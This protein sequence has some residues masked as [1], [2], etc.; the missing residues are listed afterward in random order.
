MYFLQAALLPSPV[1]GAPM[2]A[3]VTVTLRR[4]G[5]GWCGKT[6]ELFAAE[7]YRREHLLMCAACAQN[8]PPRG[9]RV[10]PGV[11][12]WIRSRLNA[13]FPEE[14]QRFLRRSGISRTRLAS[15][16]EAWCFLANSRDLAGLFD[17]WGQ[18]VAAEFITEPYASREDIEAQVAGFAG[19]LEVAYSISLPSWH[20]PWD[21]GCLR[22]VFQRPE[23]P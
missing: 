19:R 20:R 17:H 1:P 9:E 15:R 4:A 6:A 16:G 13:K 5:C 8:P 12:A 2:T 3:A 18:S 22:V 10:F 11:P 7:L 14:V 23:A 21:P